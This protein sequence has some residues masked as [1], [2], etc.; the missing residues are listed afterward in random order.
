MEQLL[1]HDQCK[2]LS[3]NAQGNPRD[4]LIY[5]APKDTGILGITFIRGQDNP[6]ANHHEFDRLLERSKDYF[7]A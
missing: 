1:I 4:E 5:Y 6:E 2:V 7:G 3:T